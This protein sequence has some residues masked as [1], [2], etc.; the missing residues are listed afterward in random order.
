MRTKRFKIVISILVIMLVISPIL[1]LKLQIGNSYARTIVL[2]EKHSFLRKEDTTTMIGDKLSENEVCKLT[3]Q[4]IK[5]GMRYRQ[6]FKIKEV[7]MTWVNKFES[8][9]VE[10]L[11][12]LEISNLT[13]SKSYHGKDKLVKGVFINPLVCDIS[14]DLYGTGET[15]F[16]AYYSDE[17][18]Q[19]YSLENMKAYY[20][21]KFAKRFELGV[22]GG[23][24]Y[25]KGTILPEYTYRIIDSTY[26]VKTIENNEEKNN[27]ANITA[28]SQ[29]AAQL[30]QTEEN[31]YIDEEDYWEPDYSYY[32]EEPQ[33]PTEK[34]I[35]ATY[36][37]KR[38]FTIR[39]YKKLLGRGASAEEI[40]GWAGTSIQ[41]IAAGLIM[42][43]EAKSKN[44][45]Y[46]SNEE[47]VKN[48]YLIL[49]QRGV[50]PSGLQTHVGMLNSG[51]TQE[52]VVRAL[53]E[54]VEFESVIKN[55]EIE[56]T[57]NE[58]SRRLYIKQLYN[59][60]LGKEPSESEIDGH[61]KNSVQ[62][63][64]VDIIMCTESINKNNINGMTDTEFITL[65]YRAIL[66]R[67]PDSNGMQS[68]LNAL[69]NGNTREQV[70]K[71][72]VE[73]DEFY[74]IR[75][76]T[77]RNIE[78]NTELRSA[79]YSSLRTSGFQ[80]MK[81]GDTTLV[82]YG[83]DIGKVNKLDISGK[84]LETLEG[85]SVFTNLNLLIAPNNKF[86][87]ISELQ[88]LTN[89]QYLN[90]DNCGLTDN[91]QSIGGLT[92]LQEL[93]IE[94]NGIQERDMNQY[95]GGLKN[96]QKL[97]L[98]NN[99]VTS[100]NFL[101]EI[102]TLK[103]LY[104]DNNMVC[105]TDGLEQSGLETI[106]VKNN[107]VELTWCGEII[108][109]IPDIL[110]VAK[111]EGSKLYTQENIELKNCKLQNNCIV[112]DAGTKEATAT[113]KG[114]NADGTVI[115]LKNYEDTIE[116]NDKVLADRLNKEI[117]R[118]IIS[119]TESNGKYILHV[120][121]LGINAVRNL[122]LSAKTDDTREITD[123][124]GLEKFTELRSLNL[125]GN[126]VSNLEKLEQLKYLD[127]LNLRF[128]GLTK[129]DSLK[130][131]TELI[132][133]DVS[134]N[135]L[136]NT[137]GLEGMIKLDTLLM[138]NNNIENNFGG[139]KNL[140][141]LTTLAIS[142]NNVTS[143]EA[144]S[145]LNLVNCYASLN[146]ISNS[147]P[148]TSIEG[149]KTIELNN[150]KIDI[151]VDG[152][153]LDVPEIIKYSMKD[154]GENNLELVN[155]RI[156]NDKI[157][158]NDGCKEAII[159]V[160]EGIASDTLVNIR[161]IET[162][163]PLSADVKYV[164]NDDKTVTAI[165]SSKSQMLPVFGWNHNATRT[166]LS[167]VYE[168]NTLE[169]VEI[170]DNNGRSCVV[171]IDVQDVECDKIPGLRVVYDTYDLTNGKVT[172]TITADVPLYIPE[173]WIGEGV[174]LWRASDDRKCI[175]QTY[176]ANGGGGIE[177]VTQENQDKLLELARKY[178]S[179][180]ITKEEYSEGYSEWAHSKITVAG[181]VTNID[182]K[183][184]TC[185]VS[186]ST[187]E[188]TR[189]SVR[190][191]IWSDEYIQLTNKSDRIL[192]E[193]IEKD[194]NGKEKYGIIQYYADN[195]KED[196]V[197]EDMAGNRSTV[198]IDINN[199]DKTLDGLG[200]NVEGTTVKDT[201]TNIIVK[202]LEVIKYKEK[203][204]E[205]SD[206]ESEM[207]LADKGMDM[208][209]FVIAS[210]EKSM[211]VLPNYRIAEVTEEEAIEESG[212]ELYVQITEEGHGIIEAKDN[213][214]NTDVAAYN[215]SVIDKNAPF[216][217]EY[218][219][220]NDD[221]TVTVTLYANEQ[222]LDTEDLAGWTLGE[223]GRTLSKLFKA[224]V[225]EA[226]KIKDMAENETIY[227][228]EVN[229]VDTLEYQV[230]FEQIENSNRVLVVIT[231]NQDLV[232]PAGW[233]KLENNNQIAKVFLIE[234]KES[235]I[236]SGINGG[237]A[238]VNIDVT[239]FGGNVF[240]EENK[241]EEHEDDNKE[242]DSKSDNLGPQA[243]IYTAF[244]GILVVVIGTV[245]VVWRKKYK[246]EEETAE[247]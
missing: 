179:G 183:A 212:E 237:S 131:L 50:D 167:R 243:G 213:Y 216:I 47:F 118:I 77:T 63:N 29:I 53:V 172:E 222:I 205:A 201:F 187:T 76:K 240:D 18:K 106:S 246:K 36:E 27:P 33:V 120:N 224:N 46:S 151:E 164:K 153:Q 190:A 159:K 223:D 149:I 80:V 229:T 173:Q 64:A 140:K 35:P 16:L 44:T 41:N 180:E 152:I 95:F 87:D 12:G 5:Y 193:V 83:E 238:V 82:M 198:T 244:A 129:L 25:Y 60:V 165:I 112:M 70:I 226:V 147:N 61:V 211:P 75:N 186:Y 85:I 176:S 188:R 89:L 189:G 218:Q 24:F 247:K 62:K 228:L 26:S 59:E 166:E 200:V 214:D 79:V 232:V 37:S 103:E 194:D 68:N 134:N 115:T 231:A 48:M 90:M 111:I 233:T 191:T 54:S 20:V 124:T 207:I 141:T 155:C 241:K 104:I 94:G 38:A 22:A 157:I 8:G 195:I 15:P 6:S 45:F 203:N 98:N 142:N 125:N 101:S 235:I 57:L 132:Q 84:N 170:E 185:E 67:E 221:G 130:N 2:T 161:N 245:A 144:L 160:K 74:K 40:D 117:P 196:I 204:T 28:K 72:F 168:Y 148:I 73:C 138:S 51:Y 202:A 7:P 158:L 34:Y 123:I 135:S 116:I 43:E 210:N 197:V 163:K 178:Q 30:A 209:F 3:N 99:N 1:Q 93:H 39:L 92:N 42:S 105:N 126:K 19:E 182:T 66:G 9:E 78:L 110:K 14:G 234:D 215:A 96:I 31:Y 154:D 139:I 91:I 171:T 81:T 69:N 150:N 137:N 108:D 113:I 177:L 136:T 217:S 206:D 242:D 156:D 102:K 220:V 58:N 162:D 127:T 143:V 225:K 181:Y 145:S 32:E 169:K 97:Y 175:S 17:D 4:Q 133:L 23:S 11:I 184:P 219:K 107:N 65:L 146:G 121:S 13:V 174:M 52:G 49:L 21:S 128:N 114:G 236:I 55:M 88:K 119:N 122:D 109:T 192:M 71:R 199:I 208:P 10:Q 56:I 230:Y 100:L 239:G 86:H 227:N